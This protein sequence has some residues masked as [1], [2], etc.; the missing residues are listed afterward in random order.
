MSVRRVVRRAREK[1]VEETEEAK[2]SQDGTSGQSVR[3]A[4]AGLGITP[5]PTAPPA[6]PG[7]DLHQ[8]H[9]PD[10]LSKAPGRLHSPV[11]TQAGV[12]GSLS[13]L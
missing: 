13:Y 6:T 11:K 2:Q 8:K 10:R 4:D 3:D 9:R 5:A 7:P 1:H 12:A